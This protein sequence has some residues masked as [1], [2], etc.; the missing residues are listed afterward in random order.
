[1]GGAGTGY[2]MPLDVFGECHKKKKNTFPFMEM[3]FFSYPKT[4]SEQ[5][6]IQ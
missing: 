4:E 3:Y 5:I 2:K 1:M 6:C